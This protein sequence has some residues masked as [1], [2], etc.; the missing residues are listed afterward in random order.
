M[1][2]TIKEFIITV[3]TDQKAQA[4]VTQARPEERQR[5]QENG[6]DAL[7]RECVE[8]TLRIMRNKQER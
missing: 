5:I 7:V 8:Q 4:P 2:V 1:P 6:Q 3:K